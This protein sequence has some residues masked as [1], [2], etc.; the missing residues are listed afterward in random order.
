MDRGGWIGYLDRLEDGPN[1]LV[2][3]ELLWNTLNHECASIERIDVLGGAE[4]D[5]AH[6]DHSIPVGVNEGED[7]KGDDV[8]HHYVGP[9]PDSADISDREQQEGIL[10]GVLGYLDVVVDV[11]GN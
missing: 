4:P 7:D 3:L 10:G 8:S 2:G 1:A 9:E 6:A 11:D 5:A